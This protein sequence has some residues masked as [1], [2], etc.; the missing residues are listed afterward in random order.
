[1]VKATVTPVIAL[2]AEPHTQ[3]DNEPS[4]GEAEILALETKLRVMQE[5]RRLREASGRSMVG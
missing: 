1:M 5:A 3:A 2:T 4:D